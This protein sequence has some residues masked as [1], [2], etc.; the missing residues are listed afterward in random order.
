MPLDTRE[1]RPAQT[2]VSAAAARG[3]ASLH[4]PPPPPQAEVPPARA[5]TPNTSPRPVRCRVSPP[6]LDPRWHP[7]KVPIGGGSAVGGG[8]RPPPRRR[9]LG[10]P[11]R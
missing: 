2:Q 9:G 8:R 11:P 7:P 3:G 5:K 10:L 1:C 4:H 6:L